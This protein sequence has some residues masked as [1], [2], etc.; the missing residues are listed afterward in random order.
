[1]DECQAQIGEQE[2]DVLVVPPLQVEDVLI[3]MLGKGDRGNEDPLSVGLKIFILD[4]YC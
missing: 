1:M 2:D 4:I 3:N